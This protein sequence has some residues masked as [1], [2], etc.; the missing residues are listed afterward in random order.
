VTKS[1]SHTEAQELFSDYREG[2]LSVDRATSVREHL[3]SCAGCRAE[4]DWFVKTV[5]ALGTLKSGAPA[6]F[7]TSV[8]GEIRRRS[9]GRFFVRKTPRFPLEI[10]SLLTLLIMLV[11]YLFMTV[12]EPK[13]VHDAPALPGGPTQT[14]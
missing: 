11:V 13:K 5:S 14:R 3:E 12:A 9:R 4:Y 6:D 8:Q 7:L 2:G 10:V 1:L